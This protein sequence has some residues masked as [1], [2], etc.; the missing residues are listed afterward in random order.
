MGFKT[1]VE[2]EVVGETGG[3]EVE[4]KNGGVGDEI[5]RKGLTKNRVSR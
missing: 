3:G 5:K 4:K 2:Y 1:M